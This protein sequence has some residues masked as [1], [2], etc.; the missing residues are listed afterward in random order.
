MA[1]MEHVLVF[2]LR[3]KGKF[4]LLFFFSKYNSEFYL[5]KL[6][7]VMPRSSTY[8]KLSMKNHHQQ[9]PINKTNHGHSCKERNLIFQ[10]NFLQLQV[11]LHVQW[12]QPC[13][14]LQN[15]VNSMLNSTLL[16]TSL[17]RLLL[18][19]YFLEQLQTTCATSVYSLYENA[20]A[21]S[22]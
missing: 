14:K 3:V 18:T 22:F 17:S 20:L 9:N 2:M 19:S 12:W 1:E 13:D 6:F 21:K 4:V 10:K 11:S 16:I 7:W 5:E 8:S 15:I